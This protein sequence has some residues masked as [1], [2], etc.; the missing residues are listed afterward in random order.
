VV[1]TTGVTEAAA[2]V[3]MVYPNPAE[4]QLYIV[5]PESGFDVLTV[6]DISGKVIESMPVNASTIIL[7]THNYQ[8][9]IY[10]IRVTGKNETMVSRFIVN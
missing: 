1:G 2:D 3:L 7:K 4:D 10:L 5:L 6:T 9:G 8:R